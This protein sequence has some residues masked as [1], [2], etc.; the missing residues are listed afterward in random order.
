MDKVKWNDILSGKA[1]VINLDRRNDR[2]EVCLNRIR[3]AGFVNVQRVRGVDGLND[4]LLE[5]WTRYG[6][7][8][9]SPHDVDFVKYMGRQGCA[10]SHYG[11]W[12]EMITQSIPYAI[13]FEDDVEFHNRWSYLSEKY[14][15]NTPR[16]FDIMYM[17]GQ[18][19]IPREGNIIVSPVFCTHAYII[20]LKGAK[21]L[22]DLCLKSSSGTY[23][24]DC[25]IIDHMKAT[26]ATN[27]QHYPFK[28]YVWNGS[29]FPDPNVHKKGSKWV[30]RNN[31][32]VF[33]DSN[34]GTDVIQW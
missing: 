19:D 9:F 12:Q 25:M 13:V 5:C 17:G 27:G 30:Q 18:I 3:E 23:T 33:Q 1:Y 15:E 16:D 26:F 24:I 21:I 10:L 11:V 14:W 32:L 31:G 2:L 29:M 8:S 4:D 7:P 34:L 22:Y 20:T 6:S 28:W